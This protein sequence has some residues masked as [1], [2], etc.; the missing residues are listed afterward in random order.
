MIVHMT[1]VQ[2]LAQS[3]KHWNRIKKKNLIF[4]TFLT[5]C[6]IFIWK[7]PPKILII[8]YWLWL[9]YMYQLH[10]HF[11][12]V[13]PFNIQFSN[14]LITISNCDLSMLQ[15]IT[16]FSSFSRQPKWNDVTFNK[17]ESPKNIFFSEN[18]L[19]KNYLMTLRV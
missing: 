13:F 1:H 6:K 17:W 2:I 7:K 15:I 18:F 11:D 16:F 10:H 12:I 3:Q 19:W 8:L 4:G 14:L 5:D 9:T